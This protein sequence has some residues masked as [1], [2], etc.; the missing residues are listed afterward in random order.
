MLV[1]VYVVSRRHKKQIR[2]G[3]MSGVA[4]ADFRE[5]RKAWKTTT[6]IIGCVFLC[7][8]PGSFIGLGELMNLNTK[9][10]NTLR[11]FTYLFCVC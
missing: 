6:I 3:Q 7:L 8:L 5:Q 9:M 2:T 4:A 11:P 10:V 1:S